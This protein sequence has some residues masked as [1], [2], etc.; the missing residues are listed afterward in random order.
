MDRELESLL[1]A[2]DAWLQA[3]ENDMD[4]CETVLDGLVDDL[5]SSRPN[6]SREQLLK[7][8]RAYYPRWLH[9]QQYPPTL[10]PKA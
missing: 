6:L 5:L 1:L 10:P 9:A 4:R 2:Y 3:G 8:L 7:A